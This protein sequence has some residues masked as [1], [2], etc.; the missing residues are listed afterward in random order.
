MDLQT[1]HMTR[2]H[3]LQPRKLTLALI[4]I[5]RDL[6]PQ[7]LQLLNLGTLILKLPPKLLVKEHGFVDDLLVFVKFILEDD[8]VTDVEVLSLVVTVV[9][10]H[11]FVFD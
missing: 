3:R 7:V 6:T 4:H 5:V 10:F 9:L 1:L 11:H 2:V 8:D